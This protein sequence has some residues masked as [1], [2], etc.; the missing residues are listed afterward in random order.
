MKCLVDTHALLWFAAGDD[1]ISKAARLQISDRSNEIFVSHASVWELAIKISLGKLKLDRNL[2]SW[3]TRFVAGN[4][5]EYLPIG[6]EHLVRVE[7]LPHR[8]GDPFDRLIVVQCEIAKMPIIS[9]DPCFDAYGM[10]RL[11]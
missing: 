6:I 9:R 10:K 1:A 11:W 8:H 5:F 3:L 7:T 4:G 2:D